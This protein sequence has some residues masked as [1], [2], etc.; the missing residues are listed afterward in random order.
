[1]STWILLRG[2]TRGQGHWGDFVSQLRAALPTG[3]Q[4]L[5]PDLPGNG[6]LCMQR[7][8]ARVEDMMQALRAMLRAQGHQPP[9]QIMAMS[10]GAMVTVAWADRYPHEIERCVLINTSLRPYSPFWHRLRPRQYPA[11]FKLLLT[12]ADASQWED[13]IMRM[14][15]R[16]PANAQAMMQNWLA[17]RQAQPVSVPNGLRQLWAASRYRAPASKPQV[18]LLLLNSLGDQLVDPA[19]SA[20]LAERWQVP[21]LRHPTAGHD[22]PQDAAPWLVE[23]VQAWLT[24]PSSRRVQAHSLAQAP[25]APSPAP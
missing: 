25:Q 21:M 13:A 4:V 10:L 16:H 1:M 20:V 17:L 14:T 11:I 15:T 6:T 22:L 12:H 3:D 7:S 19:C 2:L 9:Y 5:T 8:P 23:Q 24:Q 18:P